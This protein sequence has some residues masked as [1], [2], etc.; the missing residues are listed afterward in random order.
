MFVRSFT[1]SLS[2]S[3]FVFFH[4]LFFLS[5]SL[6]RS[7]SHSHFPTHAGTLSSSHSRTLATCRPSPSLSLCLL[8]SLLRAPVRTS[9]PSTYR[10]C[11]AASVRS[12]ASSLARPLSPSLSLSRSLFSSCLSTARRQPSIRRCITGRQHRDRARTR[13][14]YGKMEEYPR[15]YLLTSR[16]SGREKMER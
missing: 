2:L 4:A 11:T 7:M 9:C 16:L 13:H 5:L 15:A 1:L 12:L 10:N 14:A 8:P 6:S 3:D